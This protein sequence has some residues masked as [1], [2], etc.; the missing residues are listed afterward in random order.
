MK[1]IMRLVCVAMVAVL[2]LCCIGG[3][4]DKPNIPREYVGREKI[5]PNDIVKILK[6]K[7]FNASYE[8]NTISVSGDGIHALLY[9]S[10]EHREEQAVDI[11]EPYKDDIYIYGFEELDEVVPI[12]NAI[13]YITDLEFN[14]C[15]DEVVNELKADGHCSVH[16]ELSFSLLTLPRR[17]EVNMDGIDYY[18]ILED[19]VVVSLDSYPYSSNPYDE[20]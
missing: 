14:R 12:I 19:V 4:S 1:R 8:E 20:E 10:F 13:G 5:A 6:L 2:C 15:G 11:S 7:G 16:D 17:L 18:P 3:C 9:I